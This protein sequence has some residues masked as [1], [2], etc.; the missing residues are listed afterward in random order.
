MGRQQEHHSVE[1]RRPSPEDQSDFHGA[2]APNHCLPWRKHIPVKV[3][4]INA[5]VIDFHIYDRAA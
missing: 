4:W 5:P 2:S 1:A 3:G